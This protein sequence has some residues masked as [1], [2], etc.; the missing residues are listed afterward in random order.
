[1]YTAVIPAERPGLGPGS[2]SRNPVVTE[3]CV[4]NRVSDC[5]AGDYWMPAYAGMTVGGCSLMARSGVAEPLI[6]PRGACHRAAL[7][8]DPV[9]RTRWRG[10]VGACGPP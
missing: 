1:M 8:A 6:G 10:P 7:R 4:S 2:E 3:R 9:A 5:V